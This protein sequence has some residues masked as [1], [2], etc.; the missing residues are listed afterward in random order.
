[1]SDA[2]IIMG[3]AIKPKTSTDDW[4][5]RAMM[6][7]IAA[8]L[9]LA[10][11]LPLY[12]ILSKSFQDPDG[13]Y[14]GL[15]NYITYL[16][17]PALTWSIGN[18]FKVTFVATVIVLFI[19][20]IYSYALTRSCMPFKKIFKGVA[21]IPLLMPSLLP[22]IALVFFFGNQG[23]I[24]EWLF[25]YELYGPIGIVMGE[26][27]FVFPHVMTILL[28]S[29][30]LSDA[31]LYEASE[32]LGASKIRT[33]FTVTLPSM[34]YGLVS[35]FFVAFTLV[36]TDFGVPKVVGG[37]YNVLAT[38]VYKQVVGRHDFQMGAVVAMALLLPAAF[39]FI[40]DRLVQRKQ[41]ALLSARAV[42]FEPKPSFTFD[43]VMFAFCALIAL[44][45][46]SILAMAAYSSLVTFWPYNLTLTLKHY[47]FDLMDGGGW[48]S[49]FNSIELATYTAIF[50]TIVIFSG[51]YLVEKSRGFHKGR[52]M[53]QALCMVPMAVPGLVLG[54]A[55]VFFF[56]HP[57]NPLDFLYHSMPILVICTITHFYTVAHLSSVTALKQMDPEF[58]AVSQ[59]LKAPFYKTF[60]RV[61]VP[62]CTPAI[63]DVSMYLFVN[64]MTTVSAVVFLYSSDTTLASVAVL[65]MDDAGDQSP[66]AAMGMM[67]VMT[68][69]TVRLIHMVLTRGLTQ[70][71]QAWRQR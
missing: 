4:I 24:K 45:I 54:L 61:T 29:M 47:N 11:A 50:G 41:V 33:F 62:V 71:T 8:Y 32:V 63:L 48:S 35:A 19:A 1:M 25:G 5:M 44:I 58:E 49:Y 6:L 27:F 56:N 36:I 23:V 16:S 53:M 70:R 66:A 14:I 30:S 28:I 37:Q 9:L 31:R 46:T 38:D 34:R 67:I 20:F 7:A 15:T 17:T 65:N 26:V 51:A 69:A 52:S 39:A 3:K 22:A 10:I 64:A 21:L 59:S 2:A 57:D 43:M 12:A 13:M 42:P 55:Y 60:W 68:A 40:A 18:S